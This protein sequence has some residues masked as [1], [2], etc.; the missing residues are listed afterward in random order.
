MQTFVE[1]TSKKK[2]SNLDQCLKDLSSF[3]LLNLLS[4]FGVL[5][6]SLTDSY[7]FDW[8]KIGLKSNC[9]CCFSFLAVTELN[10][11]SEHL[12]NSMLRSVK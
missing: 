4:F 9:N 12:S 7:C 2:L 5:E 6:K 11:Y 8:G 3:W 1:Y 10:D